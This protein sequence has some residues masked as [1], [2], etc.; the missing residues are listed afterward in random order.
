MLVSTQTHCRGSGVPACSLGNGSA[1]LPAR[2]PGIHGVGKLHE[3]HLQNPIYF[4]LLG[5]VSL[6]W[7]PSTLG[8]AQRKGSVSILPL[9]EILSALTPCMTQNFPLPL[10]LNTVTPDNM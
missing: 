3:L 10:L 2:Y 7:H 6:T 9:A 8:D 1:T 4:Q 5:L